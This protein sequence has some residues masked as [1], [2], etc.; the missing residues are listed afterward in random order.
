MSYRYD[1]RGKSRQQQEIVRQRD[2]ADKKAKEAYEK[3]KKE[4]K[5]LLSWE[6]A[7]RLAQYQGV[8][9]KGSGK[10]LFEI[11]VTDTAIVNGP[12]GLKGT[13]IN[14]W[15]F[16]IAKSFADEV[17]EYKIYT[18]TSSNVKDRELTVNWKSLKCASKDDEN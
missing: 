7:P 4:N 6:P 16:K 15:L 8:Y 2:E 9:I 10:F 5:S 17:K 1:M 18:I 3:K 13:D 12:C 11:R 14:E